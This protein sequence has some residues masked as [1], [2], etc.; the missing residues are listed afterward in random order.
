MSFFYVLQLIILDTIPLA[1]TFKF[2]DSGVK[3]A[4]AGYGL[5][6]PEEVAVLDV[7]NL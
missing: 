2:Q 1:E 3:A 4:I 7:M 5:L 6:V